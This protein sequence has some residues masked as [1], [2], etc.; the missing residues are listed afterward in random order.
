MVDGIYTRAQRTVQ[1]LI[2]KGVAKDIADLAEQLNADPL[3]FESM[4]FGRGIM[5][6]VILDRLAVLTPELHPEWLQGSEEHKPFRDIRSCG[7][8]YMDLFLFFYTR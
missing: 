2:R 4:V 7:M 3:V 8:E 5:Q 6:S 1:Y